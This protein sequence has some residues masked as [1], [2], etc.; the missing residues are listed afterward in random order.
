MLTVVREDLSGHHP[1]RVLYFGDRAP[2]REWE[3]AYRVACSLLGVR[4]LASGCDDWECCPEFW[5]YAGNLFVSLAWRC[6]SAT[7]AQ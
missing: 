5:G 2:F 7:C 1:H 3:T 6:S 4:E